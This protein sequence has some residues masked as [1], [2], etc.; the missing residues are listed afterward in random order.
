MVSLRA[1]AGESALE[2]LGA[3]GTVLVPSRIVRPETP[4]ADSPAGTLV[5]QGRDLMQRGETLAAKQRFEEAFRLAGDAE[6]L[7][8]AAQCWERLGNDDEAEARYRQYQQLPLALRTAEAESRI[9]AI[10]ERKRNASDSAPKGP[11]RYVLVPA[12][13]VDSC[14]SAEVCRAG[15]GKGSGWATCLANQFVCLRSCPGA[16]VSRGWCPKISPGEKKGCFQSGLG[17]LTSAHF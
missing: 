1:N 15:S 17:W 13:C 11:P 14:S 10:E 7:F 3:R 2:I 16:K 9:R 4:A 8:L 12:A 5:R 6:A